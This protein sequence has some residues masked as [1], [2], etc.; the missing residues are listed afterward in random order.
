MP[1][2]VYLDDQGQAVGVAGDID[3]STRPRVRNADGSISTVR[4][5]GIS[6]DGQEIVIPTVSDD[7]RILSNE[8]AIDAYHKT[9]KYLGKFASRKAADAFAQRLHESEAAKLAPV[10]LDD[11]GEVKRAAA[12]S[13]GTRGAKAAPNVA[14]TLP[15]SGLA[16]VASTLKTP[17]LELATR[18]GATEAITSTGSKGLGLALAAKDL[19]EGHPGAAVKHAVEGVAAPAVYRIARTVAGDA[20]P[21]ASSALSGL[22]GAGSKV[23]EVA[24]RVVRMTPGL[25]A[26]AAEGDALA[27]LNSPEALADAYKATKAPEQRA[28][29]LAML[30]PEDRRAVAA[31]LFSDTRLRNDIPQD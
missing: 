25:N 15:L 9:R 20:L 8:D 31:I 4:S 22:L 18:P 12:P 7:G 2:K 16:A 24:G 23:A 1:Q 10:Y 26:I 21:S 17:L 19:Y 11:N 28:R 3:L 6:E 30:S 5:I 14:T 13:T 29:F 27:R